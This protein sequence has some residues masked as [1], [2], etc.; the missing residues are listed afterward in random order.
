VSTGAVVG[1]LLACVVERECELIVSFVAASSMPCMTK[2]PMCKAV[3]AVALLVA[4][5]EVSP[6]C[7]AIAVRLSYTAKDIC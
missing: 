2:S 5:L 1:M 4:E 6:S 3:V 7:V